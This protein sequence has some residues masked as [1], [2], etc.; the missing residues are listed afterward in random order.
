MCVK[1]STSAKRDSC[2][3]NL[4]AACGNLIQV[5]RVFLVRA[6]VEASVERICQKIRKL[7]VIQPNTRVVRKV[8]DDAC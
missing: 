2:C 8:E 6:K 3:C 4:L 5:Q 1:E 7:F